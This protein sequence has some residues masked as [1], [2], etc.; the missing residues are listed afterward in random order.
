MGDFCRAHPYSRALAFHANKG[1]ARP[2]FIS[3]EGAS[4]FINE[5]GRFRNS[6]HIYSQIPP[7]PLKQVIITSAGPR[8]FPGTRSPRRSSTRVVAPNKYLWPSSPLRRKWRER[9]CSERFLCKLH[10]SLT[11][12]VSGVAADLNGSSI[13]GGDWE[14]LPSKPR[15]SQP[16]RG[17]LSNW[18]HGFPKTRYFTNFGLKIAAFEAVAVNI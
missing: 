8:P 10:G 18:T 5:T 9:S 16:V 15:N 11:R 2:C 14:G 17:G 7:A 1:L 12:S 6:G 4:V 3:E 13:G